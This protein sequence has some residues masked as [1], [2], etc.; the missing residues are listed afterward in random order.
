[1]PLSYGQMHTK[2]RDACLTIC[3]THALSGGAP[4]RIAYDPYDTYA[5]SWN[6]LY[7]SGCISDTYVQQNL[8]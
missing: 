8:Q 2:T 5:R 3:A 4:R 7:A 6:R 1:M